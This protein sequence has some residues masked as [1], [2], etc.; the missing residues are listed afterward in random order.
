MI[1]H[2]D[3]SAG[4]TRKLV[5]ESPPDTC[6]ASV[7]AHRHSPSCGARR[8][9]RPRPSRTRL[10][11]FSTATLRQMPCSRDALA[12]ECGS[13]G[14]SPIPARRGQSLSVRKVH[15]GPPPNRRRTKQRIGGYVDTSLASKDYEAIRG[16][17][18]KVSDL[19]HRRETLDGACPPRS[20]HRRGP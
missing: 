1:A 9:G 17:V 19:A 20:W 6:H 13:P 14:P 7:S 8:F 16:V 3:D 2:A 12:A 11:W 15:P 5:Y 18:N 4:T 10:T